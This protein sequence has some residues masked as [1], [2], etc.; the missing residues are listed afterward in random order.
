MCAGLRFVVSCEFTYCTSKILDGF[1]K[2]SVFER[3]YKEF[4][5][6]LLAFVVLV[7]IPVWKAETW[8]FFLIILVQVRCTLLAVML[9]CFL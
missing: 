2:P 7:S 5:V 3:I 8:G 6:A 1:P 9:K 4:A